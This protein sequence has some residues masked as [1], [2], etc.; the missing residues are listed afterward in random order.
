[1]S[2]ARSP[3]ALAARFRLLRFNAGARRRADAGPV[4]RLGDLGPAVL[5]LLD[6]Y[7]I[8]RAPYYAGISLGGMIG[9][10]LAAHAPA[11]IAALGLCCTSACLPPASGW[12]DRAALVRQRRD[13]AGHRAGAGRWFTPPSGGP[14]R[15]GLAAAMLERRAT[16]RATRAAAR[17]SAD[18][19]APR[20]LGSITAPT[21]VIAGAEDPVTPPA[22][23]AVIAAG[24]AGARLRV[25]RGAAHLANLA[26]GRGDRGPAQPPDW[27][28]RLSS[29]PGA[30]PDSERGTRLL[31]LAGVARISEFGGNAA[32][33]RADWVS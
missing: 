29:R 11:R 2:G 26:A 30:A 14:R 16:R 13:G 25:I 23:G 18:G 32:A 33:A 10:W 22:H 7:G 31:C 15:G 5:D 4:L 19:P 28:C 24:I 8:D 6:R 12:L 9:M 1:M 17:R 27:C 21:L 20:S 3:R